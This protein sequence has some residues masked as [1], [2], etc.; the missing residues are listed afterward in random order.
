MTRFI[1]ELLL[2]LLPFA[3]FAL[4]LLVRRRNPLHWTSWD[5]NALRLVVAGLAC[6]ILSLLAA[7][8]MSDREKGA[9]VPAH[10]E[11]GRL[12]PGQFK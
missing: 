8:F 1:D 3:V 12:V 7:F 5:K 2:F 10:M 9:F 4:Y 6:V 11:D